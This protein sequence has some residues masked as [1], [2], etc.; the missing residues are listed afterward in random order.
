MFALNHRLAALI[1]VS[2]V[3]VACTSSTEGSRESER[4]ESPVVASS[5][6]QPAPAPKP[7]VTCPE[8]DV[9]ACA[10]TDELVT[11]NDENGCSYAYCK[12]AACPPVA[13]PMCAPNTELVSG[14]GED[15]CTF[16]YCKPAACP[17]VAV[18]QCAPGTSLKYTTDANGCSFAECE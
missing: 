2:F 12:P 7:K 17:P 8:I 15:G 3:S 11:G 5:G 10:S 16:A 1:A 18:P 9:P 13:T 4:T 14:I 6:N